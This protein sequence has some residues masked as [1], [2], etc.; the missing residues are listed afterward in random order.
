MSTVLCLY[1]IV[2][3]HFLHLSFLSVIT[4]SLSLS[5][6]LFKKSAPSFVLSLRTATVT[7]HLQTLSLMVMEEDWD[8]FAVIRPYTTIT[9]GSSSSTTTTATSSTPSSSGFE[10]STSCNFSLYPTENSSQ[11]LSLSNPLEPKKPIE[12]LHDLCKPF[13]LKPQHLSS[14]SFS[15]SS[16]SPKSPHIQPKQQQLNKNSHHVVSATTPRSKRR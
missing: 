3:S 6:S 15:Y 8:L 14:N 11:V 2:F 16:P 4:I 9:S 5:L 7:E 1:I 10:T 13:F 12:E